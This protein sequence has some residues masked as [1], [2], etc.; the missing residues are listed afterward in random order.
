METNLG[1]PY[2]IV[3]FFFIMIQ[4]NI[5]FK[6]E[7]LKTF[8]LHKGKWQG[9]RGNSYLVHT[10]I[11]SIYT[12]KKKW[13]ITRKLAAQKLHTSIEKN[14]HITKPDILIENEMAQTC[15]SLNTYIYM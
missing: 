4:N 15:T 7:A 9:F 11:N 3:Q 8:N 1:F 13:H 14:I 2:V 10:H 5:F 12:H 6:E